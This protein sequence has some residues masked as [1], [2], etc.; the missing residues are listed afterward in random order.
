M[1]C[2]WMP[3]NLYYK[4]SL[5][6]MSAYLMVA[7]VLSLY[8]I[9]NAAQPT[10]NIGILLTGGDHYIIGSPR[11]QPGADIALETVKKRISEGEYVN[12]TITSFYRIT[13]F[14]CS[15]FH[16]TALGIASDLYYHNGVVGY[17]GP[18]CS[19]PALGVADLAAHWN[20]PVVSGVATLTDLGNKVRFPTL[21]R[22][23]Y[24]DGTLAAF[25]FRIFQRYEWRRCSMVWDSWP[26]FR[27][28]AIAVRDYL[29]SKE[30]YIHDAN[31]QAYGSM[32]EAFD[33]AAVNGRSKYNE[34]H[35]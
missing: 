2:G 18:S 14:Y 12:F 21:T 19:F 7:A 22:T 1:Q 13:E 23:G 33:D 15:P 25:I 5:G 4:V 28:I 32:E 29:L 31:I 26:T 8:A 10:V 24:I 11:V 30:V 35:L 20:V 9:P 27:L 34:C 16:M 3:I 6:K 17:I